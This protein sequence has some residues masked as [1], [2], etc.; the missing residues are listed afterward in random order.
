MDLGARPPVAR[1]G[2]TANA[3]HPGGVATG[4]FSKGGGLLGTAADVYSRI[5][6]RTPEQGA[7][8]AVWLAAAPELADV[9]GRFYMDRSEKTCAFRNEAQEE[10]L[11]ALCARMTRGGGQP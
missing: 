8:T 1:E 5:T 9:S 3:M 11:W 7:D 4:I 6:G 2:V 10:R